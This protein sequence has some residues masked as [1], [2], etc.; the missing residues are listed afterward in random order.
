MSQDE[1]KTEPKSKS[2][3]DDAAKL[4]PSHI[5]L[6]ELGDGVKI[7]QNSPSIHSDDQPVKPPTKKFWDVL[8]K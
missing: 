4:G 8:P 3:F 2:E 7:T 6:S 5:T 1:K